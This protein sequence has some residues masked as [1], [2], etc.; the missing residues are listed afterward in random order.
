[1]GESIQSAGWD[2]YKVRD[3]AGN[4]GWVPKQYVREGD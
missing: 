2:W 4:V 1:M 3:P